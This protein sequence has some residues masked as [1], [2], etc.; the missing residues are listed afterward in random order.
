MPRISA[1]VAIVGGGVQGLLI[2][3]DLLEQNYNAVLFERDR[4]G[5]GQ[6]GH[7]HVFLHQGHMF[8]G[9]KDPEQAIISKM[10][11]LQKGHAAWIEQLDRPRFAGLKAEHGPK[12]FTGFI[13]HTRA[14]DF[15]RYCEKAGLPCSADEPPLEFAAGVLNH[16]YSYESTCLNANKLVNKL[17]DYRNA[18]ERVV[19]CD[20]VE[21][22]GGSNNS[23][24]VKAISS[25]PSKPPTAEVQARAVVFAA[26]AGNQ[27]LVRDALVGSS[28]R[29]SEKT[30][31]QQTLKTYM[32]VLQAKSPGMSAVSGC[33]FEL[34][35][36]FM[37]PRL[38]DRG[39]TTWLVADRQRFPVFHP[40]DWTRTEP[41]HWFSELRPNLGRLVP[42]LGESPESFRWG[43]YESPKAEVHTA[44]EGRFRNGGSLPSNFSVTKCGSTNAWLTWPTFLTYAPLVSRQIVEE[45]LQAL[46]S[47]DTSAT[48]R[49]PV[50]PRRPVAAPERWEV[51]PL[52]EWGEF[53]RAYSLLAY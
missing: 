20:H 16:F 29:F 41:A 1:D 9:G 35:G 17:L 49:L 45:I 27:R 33:F 34:N 46:R 7:S 8:G 3:S 4:P 5:A 25:D 11:D 26:G 38:D 30:C 40:G 44:G 47:P 2:L 51:T 50:D 22:S 53:R 43:I 10:Q 31:R 48:Q 19:R 21:V 42:A 12:F 39:I 52:L 24:T 13:D 23:F 37:A 15:A 32:L 36:I 18:A 6:T 14:R 28:I